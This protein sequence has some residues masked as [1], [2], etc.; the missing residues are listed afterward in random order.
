MIFLYLRLTKV[1]YLV[2]FS[3]I[4]FNGF[5]LAK[6]FLG[7]NFHEIAQNLQKLP[8]A[9]ITSFKLVFSPTTK[10]SN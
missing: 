8:P 10:L 1:G 6:N 7:I 9:K 4:A 2:F 5:I 3:S